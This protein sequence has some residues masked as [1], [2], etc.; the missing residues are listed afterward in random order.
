MAVGAVKSFVAMED[1]LNVIL[2]GLEVCEAL[3]GIAEHGVV[4]QCG[5]A[6]TERI[7]SAA[8]DDLRGRR[9]VDLHTRFFGRI[10]GE[11]EQNASI[12]R[13][14]A[15]RGWEADFETR[16]G[17]GGDGE[18]ERESESWAREEAEAHLV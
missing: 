14:S 8:E 5:L 18:C 11:D 15:A 9:V 3:D 17:E 13:R 12:E 6:G 1:G 2:T 7:D 4:D 16:G 10:S